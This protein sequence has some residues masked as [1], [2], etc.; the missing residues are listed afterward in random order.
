MLGEKVQKKRVSSK[1]VWASLPTEIVQV[2]SELSKTREGI[3]VRRRMETNV[4]RVNLMRKEIKRVTE[5]LKMFFRL[6]KNL[7]KV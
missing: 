5:K 3:V 2:K 4:K 7:R 6:K 1:D